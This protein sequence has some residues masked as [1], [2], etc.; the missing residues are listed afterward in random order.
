M[1]EMRIKSKINGLVALR[2]FWIK[3]MVVGVILALLSI[4]IS[5]LENAYCSVFGVTL[6]NADGRFIFEPRVLI[7]DAVA[8]VISFLILSPLI[9]GMF[10]WYWNI[11]DGK[12][13]KIGDIFAWYGSGK[14]YGKSLL[15][16]LN[17]GIRMILWS[18]L[19]FAVPTALEIVGNLIITGIGTNVKQ[20]TGDMMMK[21]A[22][23]AIC[24]LGG[25]LLTLGAAL[26]YIFIIS[27][28]I[29]AVYLF[30]ENKDLKSAEAIKIS[31]KYSKPYR[32][33]YTKFVLSYIGWF[34]TCIFLLPLLY[35][36]PY[37]FSSLTVFTKSIIYTERGKVK[38]DET[39][40]FDVPKYDTSDVQ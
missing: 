17:I 3:S 9:I 29:P 30:T 21:Y 18:I 20:M 36:I 10:E 13:T 25:F 5:E 37:F 4:G 35:V 7:V 2:G 12:E 16:S 26:L 22:V 15:L 11:T 31:V 14:L 38:A 33:E 23:G 6:I 34:I 27:R 19:L 28:Y 1:S 8:T 24:L 32:W 40:S 39:K